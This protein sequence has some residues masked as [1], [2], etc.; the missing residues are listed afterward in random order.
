[1]PSNVRFSAFKLP[2]SNK[3]LQTNLYNA[4]INMFNKPKNR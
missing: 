4:K 2:E 1:M 3:F